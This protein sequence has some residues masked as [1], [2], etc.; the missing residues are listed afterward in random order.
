MLS[1][2]TRDRCLSFRKSKTKRPPALFFLWP[3]FSGQSNRMQWLSPHPAA[4]AASYL[5]SRQPARSTLQMPSLPADTSLTETLPF[6][7]SITT[8]AAVHLPSSVL[9]RTVNLV[10][11]D[12]GSSRTTSRACIPGLALLLFPSLLQGRRFL[13][14]APPFLLSLLS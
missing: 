5:L 12:L 3:S 13:S 8:Q 14:R 9:L 4:E 2:A 10:Q 11:C 1:E 7:S 6:T